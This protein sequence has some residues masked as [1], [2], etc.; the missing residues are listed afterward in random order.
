[1]G[2]LPG[3]IVKIDITEIG[4]FDNLHDP[5]GILKTL[6]ERTAVLYGAEESF[7][8]VNGST[9]GILSAVSAAVPQGGHILMARNCHKSAYHAAYLRNLKISY[10]YPSLL[11]GYDIY[12]AVTPRQVEEGLERDSQVSAVL[13][14]SPTYEGRIA[15]VKTIAE[16]VHKRGIPLIV[17]EAHGAHLEFSEYFA[18]NS[19]SCGADLVIHSVHKTLPA[20]TQSALLHVNGSRIDRDKLRRF[21]HIYQ[22]SSPSYVLLAG[23]DDALEIVE[24]KGRELFSEFARQYFQMEERL[25]QCRCLQWISAKG[26]GRQDIGKLVIS[27]R[28]TELSGQDLYDIL[29]QKYNLQL[30]MAEGSYCLAMFTAA[31]PAEAYERMTA[32]LLEIDSQLAAAYEQKEKRPEETR[33]PEEHGSLAEYRPPGESGLPENSGGVIPLTRAWD[34]KAKLIPLEASRGKAAA[35]FIN[36]FP[37]GIPILVPGEQI[38]EEAYRRIRLCLEQGLTVQ[39]IVGRGKSYQIKVLDI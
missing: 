17:D 3:E 2:D 22:S 27:T 15:D 4:D 13:L 35:E 9:G 29:I 1:M 34:M 10:L 7:Y 25:S 16:I 12:D 31:D 20:L 5:R 36:L 30:E 39:G 23:I 6:Q 19:C 8:L 26:D 21:L 37:P 32:A 24:R 11:P 28:K 33:P 14:V 18:P 38:S